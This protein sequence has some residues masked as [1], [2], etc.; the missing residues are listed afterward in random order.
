MGAGASVNL[1]EE[2]KKPLD[3]SDVLT[4]RGE[5]V[6]AELV[7][8]RT[9]LHKTEFEPVQ[10]VDNSLTDPEV[11]EKDPNAAG[12]KFE[13]PDPDDVSVS[14][15]EPELT[16]EEELALRK[17][18]RSKTGPGTTRSG[19]KDSVMS[20]GMVLSMAQTVGEV[21]SSYTMTSP[22]DGRGLGHEGI[23]EVTQSQENSPMPEK[24]VVV[25]EPAKVEGESEQTTV[26]QNRPQMREMD[27]D[28][29]Y[30]EEGE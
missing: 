11:L 5:S 15:S 26:E 20:Q 29:P 22:T 8:L 13:I 23:K 30:L 1:N 7:R 9:L 10:P 27:E 2:K 18:R 14:S 6:K 4:P 28:E 12:V 19:R 17:K 21:G 24:R 16:E 25:A 3:L